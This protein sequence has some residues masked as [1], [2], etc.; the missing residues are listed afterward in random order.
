M[1]LQYDDDDEDP[2]PH[3]EPPDPTPNQ[4]TAKEGDHHLSLNATKG[5]T[6]VGTIRFSGT[7][8]NIPVQVLLDGGSSESFIQPRIAQFLKLPVESATNFRVLIGNGQTMQTEGWLPQLSVL[9]QGH[10]LQVPVH[11]LPVGGADLIL[12]S[13]W[14]ATLGLYVADYATLV[15]KFFQQGK[16]ITLQG[17]KNIQPTQAQLH[18]L[19][20]MQSTDSIFEC[21]SIQQISK[22]PDNEELLELP[23]NMKP[24][25]I[26]LLHTYGTV[27]QSST[28][29]PPDRNHSHAI[30]LQPGS[31]LVNVRPYHTLTARNSKLS[32]WFR[33][34]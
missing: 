15:I 26:N 6:G 5:G 19:R 10:E 29:L 7:I 8:G 12:G 16:F 33:K 13:T 11:L 2:S 32:S 20:R 18:Q 24:E 23:G 27:F 22:A 9:I 4:D 28:G 1:M 31:K 30:P 17:D 14:L 34:C 21:F 3:T 25:L